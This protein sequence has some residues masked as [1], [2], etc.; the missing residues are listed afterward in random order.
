[1]ETLTTQPPTAAAT[2][3]P[4]AA[5]V[6]SNRRRRAPVLPRASSFPLVSSHGASG[7]KPFLRPWRP[8]GEVDPARPRRAP[9]MEAGA[10]SRERRI[11]PHRPH[12]CSLALNGGDESR[13]EVAAARE[14]V[15]ARLGGAGGSDFGVG[16][17]GRERRRRREADVHIIGEARWPR[18]HTGVARTNASVP[19]LCRHGRRE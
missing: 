17:A 9:A 1:L 2:W 5:A 13:P 4:A 16:T 6:A 19:W 3:C 15:G 11:H 18:G 10:A 14:I 7:P 12:P 8:A